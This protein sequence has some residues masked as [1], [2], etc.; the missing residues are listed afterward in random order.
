MPSLQDSQITDG[1]K[2]GWHPR[3]GKDQY[4]QQR[5]AAVF[6]DVMKRILSVK[7]GL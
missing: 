7:P 1:V 2:Y 3:R 4:I 6:V 5:M